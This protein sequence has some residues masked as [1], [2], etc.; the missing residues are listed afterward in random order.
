MYKKQVR[1]CKWGYM[2]NDNEDGAENGKYIKLI[3]HELA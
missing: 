1:L 2:T 3:R